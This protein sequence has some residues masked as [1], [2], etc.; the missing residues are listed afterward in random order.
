MRQFRIYADV[1]YYV[2]FHERY[3]GIQPLFSCIQPG[4]RRA[5]GYWTLGFAS[6]THTTRLAL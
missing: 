4:L 2:T 5:L 3:R 6:V 1:T